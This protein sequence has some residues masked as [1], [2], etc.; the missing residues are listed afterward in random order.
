[1]SLLRIPVVRDPPAY[2]MSVA[3]EGQTYDFAIRYNIRS[4]AWFV[5]IAF[6]GQAVVDG[7]R[8]VASDNLL[9]RWVYKQREGLL[10]PGI[11]IV[12][13][14]AGLRRDP[15]FDTF[16]SDVLLLYRES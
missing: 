11:F 5:S 4:A 6:G 10:P 9:Y 15:D 3:L 7:Q 13:D 14:T 2:T 12:R 16:G 8:L 1:M